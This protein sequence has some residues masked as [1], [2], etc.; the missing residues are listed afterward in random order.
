M[1]RLIFYFN[2]CL[3]HRHQYSH[4]NGVTQLI[5]LS[6]NLKPQEEK[7]TWL[8]IIYRTCWPPN[9]SSAHVPIKSHL[10]DIWMPKLGLKTHTACGDGGG[11]RTCE[12]PSG[13]LWSPADRCIHRYPPFTW[14]TSTMWWYTP[15]HGQTQFWE[16]TT[17]SNFHLTNI[18]FVLLS[19]VAQ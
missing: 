8:T 14:H 10:I 18:L 9:L 16:L 19:K 11:L 4:N 15:G 6:H 2:L 12:L 7:K 17:C 13:V 3:F 1:F 5:W